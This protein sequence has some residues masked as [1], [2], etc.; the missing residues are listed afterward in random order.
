MGNNPVISNKIEKQKAVDFEFD[1]R[2]IYASILKDWF[3]V[4]TS[5]IQSLFE[6]QIIFYPLLSCSEDPEVIDLPQDII[7][8]PNPTINTTTLVFSSLNENV[9]LTIYDTSG[10]L[11][12][13]VFDKK[14]PEE[15][16]RILID[17]SSLVAGNYILSVKKESGNLIV[18]LIIAEK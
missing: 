3:L 9:S 13:A 10:R 16:H 1:F 12:K 2:N 8:Y 7:A 18:R 17:V 4:P 5:Q 14:L 15:E 11:I 6:H